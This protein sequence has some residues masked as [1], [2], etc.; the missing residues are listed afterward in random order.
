MKGR[1]LAGGKSLL[2]LPDAVSFKRQGESSDAYL[3]GVLDDAS[4]RIRDA[5]RCR[6]QPQHRRDPVEPGCHRECLPA[7]AP[8]PRLRGQQLAVFLRG[9]R[10]VAAVQALRPG[11]PRRRLPA[12]DRHGPA[13]LPLPRRRPFPR[14]PRPPQRTTHQPSAPRPGTLRE[15]L[16]ALRETYCRNVGVEYMHIQ[17]ANVR[18]WLQERIWNAVNCVSRTS[19]WRAARSS[20]AAARGTRIGW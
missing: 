20:C 14:P 15:L 12:A 11:R 10:A 17:D 19:T 3:G 8:G 9:L 13:D 6:T 4:T 5:A 16:E 1:F 7:L 18:A 2:V